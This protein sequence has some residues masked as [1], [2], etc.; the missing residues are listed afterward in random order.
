MNC[1]NVRKIALKAALLSI[2]LALVLGSDLMAQ[3]VAESNPA[4]QPDQPAPQRWLLLDNGSLIHGR[5]E[6]AAE[7]FTVQL[8]EGGKI[9]LARQRVQMVANSPDQ[10]YRFLAARVPDLDSKARLKL[11]EWCIEQ[12]MLPQ[13][14]AEIAL[15]ARRPSMAKNTERLRHRVSMLQSTAR[16]R[17]P[18]GTA[19]VPNTGPKRAAVPKIPESALV[20]FSKRIQP[21]MINS[22]GASNCH[23]RTS[24]ASFRLVKPPRGMNRSR[25]LTQQNLVAVLQQV[26]YARPAK[27]PLLE[28]MEHKH[29]GIQPKA[30]FPNEDE[31]KLSLTR[32]V[33]SVT[34]TTIIAPASPAPA[35]HV[36]STANEPAQLNRPKG[37][38]RLQQ[39]PGVPVQ[40]AENIFSIEDLTETRS[41][42]SK[43][44]RKSKPRKNRKL[45]IP[46][47][48][49]I[50][51]QPSTTDEL[52][53]SHAKIDAAWIPGPWTYP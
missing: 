32:W 51:T 19:R 13:A 30:L 31:H 27:S 5:I 17:P 53:S 25:R 11:A 40:H 2:G 38:S 45:P 8:A 44:L 10:A 42:W 15:L 16:P 4:T 35:A 6:A 3:Q 43:P 52:S 23:G 21:L 7:S 24:V 41:N 46:S 12:R 50:L 49:T 1:A 22:C 37:T 20:E 28:I 48:P 39:K 33:E 47:R 26:D 34:G 29:A 36:A 18:V 14:Q 9:R